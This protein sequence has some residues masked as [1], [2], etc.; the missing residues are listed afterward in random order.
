MTLKRKIFEVRIEHKLDESPDLSYLGEYS[1][2]A[3][4]DLAIDRKERGDM[5]QNEFRFFN[6]A[7]GPG[8]C[9][10]DSTVPIKQAKKYIEQDYARCE[11]YNRG[12]W[13]Y[14]GIAAV[15]KV[16]LSLDGGKTF[17]TEKIRSGGLWGIES[18]SDR[19]Y[20]RSVEDEELDDLKR[21]LAVCGFGRSVIA[22]A[23]KS[24]ERSYE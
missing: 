2:S 10:Y 14:M 9:N 6:A 19:T 17:T 15:A 20:V 1:S 4:S 8:G 24:A 7:S 12:D 21:L 13:H 5:N 18:D 23:I 11:S 22:R 3:D 16:G